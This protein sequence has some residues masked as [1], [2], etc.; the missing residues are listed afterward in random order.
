[1]GVAKQPFRF[2][3]AARDDLRHGVLWYEE[4]REGLGAR[5]AADVQKALSEV[6]KG[7]DALVLVWSNAG[8]TFLVL[9]TPQG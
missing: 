3:R 7:S 9:H 8:S 2:S 4:A 5:F 1:M 6:P